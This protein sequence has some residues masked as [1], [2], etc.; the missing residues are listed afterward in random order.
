L[1]QATSLWS[2]KKLTQDANDRCSEFIRAPVLFVEGSPLGDS[3]NH[4]LA[5][6]FSVDMLLFGLLLALALTLVLKFGKKN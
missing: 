6:V 5:L 1:V 2:L 3:V 4:L